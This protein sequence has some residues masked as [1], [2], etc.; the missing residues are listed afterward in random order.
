MKAYP[1]I[2]LTY[3]LYWAVEFV[4]SG[5]SIPQQIIPTVVSKRNDKYDRHCDSGF[6]KLTRCCVYYPTTEDILKYSVSV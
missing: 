5:S 2:V 4:L 1:R 6:G 3:N